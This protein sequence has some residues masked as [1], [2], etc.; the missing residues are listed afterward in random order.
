MIKI[1]L[2]VIT[3]ALAALGLTEFVYGMRFCALAPKC[4]NSAT[5]LVLKEKDALSELEF[6]IFRSK[7]FGDRYSTCIIAITDD[8]TEETLNECRKLT[9]DT[10]VVLVPIKYFEN[11]VNA[12]F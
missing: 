1:I 4:L 8:L 11:V 9:E 2:L 10:D 12:I 7:W 5:V 6:A 3:V